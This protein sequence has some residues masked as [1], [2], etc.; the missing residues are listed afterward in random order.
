MRKPIF[1]GYNFSKH[2]IFCEKKNVPRYFWK[3]EKKLIEDSIPLQTL[4]QVGTLQNIQ[5]SAKT[6]KTRIIYVVNNTAVH[7]GFEH[8]T[9]GRAKKKIKI[10]FWGNKSFVSSS[11][12]SFI[13]VGVVAP[14]ANTEVSRNFRRHIICAHSILIYITMN[15]NI[16][17]LCDIRE[18]FEGTC[19]NINLFHERLHSRTVLR[20][21]TA[22]HR[23]IISARE[24]N[25]QC[26]VI[27]TGQGTFARL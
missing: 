17:I 25:H 1:F 7:N 4:S 3:N 10:K 21:S 24:Y 9:N 20:I 6:I 23:Y 2:K 18:T 15:R 13:F 26:H 14:G 8:K 19:N 16:I 11:C 5:S 22:V 27:W 12:R